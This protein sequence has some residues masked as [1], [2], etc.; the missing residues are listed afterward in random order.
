MIDRWHPPR[1]DGRVAVVTGAS[2]GGGRGIALALGSCKATVYVTGRSTERS[3]G[4]RGFSWTIDET[5]RLVRARGGEAIP[6]RCDHTDVA[7]VKRLFDRV[8]KDHGRLD[9]LV[10]NVWG[11]YER[12]EAG[13]PPGPFWKQPLWQWEAMFEAGLRAHL[14]SSYFAIP[15]MLPRRRGLIINTI[16]WERGKYL[17]HLYYDLAKQAIRRLAYDLALELRSKGIAAL[18][19]A[20]G[21]MRSELVLAAHRKH[22]FDLG[23]TESTEYLGRAVAS[24]AADP[25]VITKTGKVLT[26]AALAREYGFTDTDGRWVP[27][28]RFPD[29]LQMD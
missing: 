28:F 23:P 5:A 19:L 27:A 3:G 17:L 15:I 18:A 7:Q 11:G 2:R 22:P 10:N 24:L 26:V 16:A 25:K 13:L 12:N 9:V 21:F 29:N 14:L 1:L 8:R 4:T 20:P 6:V